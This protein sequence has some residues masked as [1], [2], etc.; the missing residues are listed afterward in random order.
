[1][2]LIGWKITIG[3]KCQTCCA[4]GVWM[5]ESCLLGICRRVLYTVYEDNL[6]VKEELFIAWVYL[7]LHILTPFTLTVQVT[8][9]NPTTIM[10]LLWIIL[11][12][13]ISIPAWLDLTH[14]HVHTHT[15]VVNGILFQAARHRWHRTSQNR[16][17]EVGEVKPEEFLEQSNGPV[18]LWNHTDEGFCYK[19]HICGL[20]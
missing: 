9:N 20:Q 13:T 7:C 6:S 10:K 2:L 5:C 4:E 8:T 15:H 19:H 3:A 14:T 16:T 18:C 17:A 11:G 1:M 12:E